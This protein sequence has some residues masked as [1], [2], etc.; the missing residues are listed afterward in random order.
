[1]LVH[2]FHRWI[3]AV[4]AAAS[5]LA[6]CGC[7]TGLDKVRKAR[8]SGLEDG[9]FLAALGQSRTL[10]RSDGV[11]LPD[12]AAH[13]GLVFSV[14]NYSE[15]RECI[16]RLVRRIDAAESTLEADLQ[17][18]L[19]AAAQAAAE[20]EHRAM[21]PELKDAYRAK[22]WRNGR[23]V[24]GWRDTRYGV[25]TRLALHDLKWRALYLRGMIDLETGDPAGARAALA[26]A[27]EL[28]TRRWTY[29]D[30]EGR[31]ASIDLVALLEGRQ[32]W[33]FQSNGQV[34]SADARAWWIN[35]LSS[36]SISAGAS[37]D[38]PGAASAL[39]ELQATEVPRALEGYK[40]SRLA[41]AHMAAGHV[42]QAKQAADADPEQSRR[43]LRVGG[44]LLGGMVLVYALV[45]AA[46]LAAAP[47]VTISAAMANVAAMGAYLVVGITASVLTITV[48]RVAGHDT[49]WDL[50]QRWYAVARIS[51]A[52]GDE[53]RAE[54]MYRKL[55]AQDEVL[56]SQPGIQWQVYADVAQR[57]EAAGR[58][59]EAIVFYEKAVDVIEATRRNIAAET[60]KIGFIADKQQVY[61]R[62][63]RLRLKRGQ[64]GPAFE[65]SEQAR[66]RALLDSLASRDWTQ[67][68]DAGLAQQGQAVRALE[69]QESEV[70]LA[71][72]QDQPREADRRRGAMLQ[73]AE[74]LQGQDRQ[75][76]A[77]THV[78][79]YRLD[80]I[81]ERLA[82]AEVLVS[83]VPM[84]D[85]L[86]VFG[87][88]RTMLR[89]WTVPAGETNARVGL[90]RHAIEQRSVS[91]L[92]RRELAQLLFAGLRDMGA[93]ERLTVV[94][95]G[96]LHALP[97]A[98]LQ[99]HDGDTGLLPEGA[100]LRVLPSASMLP[101]LQGR[102]RP[103]VPMSVMAFG[104][105]DFGGR[106]PQLPGTEGEARS[107]ARIVGAGRVVVGRE[108]TKEELLQHAT[109]A[110]VLHFATHGQFDPQRPMQSALFLSDGHGGVETLTAADFYGLRLGARLVTLS[111]C[112][113]GLGSVGSGDEVIGLYRG[114]MFAG[115]DTLVVSLWDVDDASTSFLMTRFYAHL[116]THT[117]PQALQLAQRD[118]AARWPE[119]YHWAGFTLIGL[120]D[121]FAVSAPSAAVLV[122]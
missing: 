43:N 119:P 101:L 17:K 95:S 90:L 19:A 113:T 103:P 28:A 54:E 55:L 91:T 46:A 40:Q 59:D 42:A 86:V 116:K 25:E 39:A 47:A 37:G 27:H 98:A 22:V 3:A 92:Q 38:A 83:F 104:N 96:S 121:P 122:H 60:A 29:Q 34:G 26:Q 36:L 100:A 114:L 31:S 1:M 94:P 6:L 66:A 7:A 78:R 76:A 79:R 53:A 87:L 84:G 32:A 16:E 15:A 73:L 74:Q 82:P 109:E 115:A 18:R 99:G 35:L 89:H 2:R 30:D 107:V 13:C 44:T 62:L 12:L 33:F 64:V 77:L 80:E 8:D 112:E 106:L 70:R 68:L 110:S 118:T 105:P 93:V 48:S 49:T 69:A 52:S 81:R 24:E 102:Q 4:A 61:Q 45:A 63:M 85:Q 71:L 57:H 65:L 108:A 56:Q 50:T 111:A 41:F 21:P 51:A 72:L 10:Y 117:A 75:L 5:V 20:S 67:A 11:P 120:D 58:E 9:N 88:S 14:A 97:F 23:L